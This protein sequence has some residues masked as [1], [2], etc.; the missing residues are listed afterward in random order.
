MIIDDHSRLLV[1]GGLFYNDNAYNFQKVLKDAVAAYGIP[2]KLYVDNGCSYS[3][4][5]LSLICGAVGIVL[6]HTRVRDGASKAKTERQ[7]RTLKET[8]LYILDLDSITFL[9]QFDSLLKD[10]MRSYNTTL[11]SSIGTTPG[12]VTKVH[13]LWSACQNPGSGSKNASSTA[14]H[15]KSIRI[16]PSPLTGFLMTSPCSSSPPEWRSASCRTTC[17]RSLSFMRENA[18]QSDR[19]IKM[20]TAGQS[21]TIR[22]LLIIQRS[23]VSADVPFL[24]WTVV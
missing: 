8:W 17:S 10:Y 15:A 4:E 16:P 23:G 12:S 9:K 20:R 2:S 19:R 18:F 22:L 3:N 21:V 24:L 6:L 13:V 11:H 14:S 7:F 1:G 5:Q